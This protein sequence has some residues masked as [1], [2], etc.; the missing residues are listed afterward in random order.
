[1]EGLAML[2]AQRKPY[3]G[4]A[5]EGVI[6]DW[7]AKNTGRDLYPFRALAARLAERLAPGAKILEIAPGPGYLAIALAH[8]GQYDITGLDISRS[9]VTIASESA[10]KAGVEVDF[11]VGDAAAMPFADA[12]FDFV[13]CRAA[14]KNFTEPMQA[15]REMQRVLKPAGRALI[16]D[17]RKD[18]SSVA[19]DREVSNMNLP[20]LG[21]AMTAAILKYALR[22]RAY[23]L[24]DM[25]TMAAVVFRGCEIQTGGEPSM[26]FE[27]WLTK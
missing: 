27:A 3:K 7:Y 15:L 17:L 24:A 8:L 20:W 9:F 19:I 25:R 18:A 22:P 14:F 26:G 23:S 21:R 13:V 12:S 2:N 10:A 11:R 1:M 16:I 5:M 4:L 6:A